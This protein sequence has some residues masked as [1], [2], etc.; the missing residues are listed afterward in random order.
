MN[1]GEFNVVEFAARAVLVILGAGLILAFVRMLKGP[2]LP[3]RVAAVDAVSMLS[4]CFI[5]VASILADRAVFLD[6]AMV[7]ALVVFLGTVA[8]A[9]YVEKRAK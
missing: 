9:R 5:A 3:D 2:T 7:L 6:A 8:F 4:V 1:G